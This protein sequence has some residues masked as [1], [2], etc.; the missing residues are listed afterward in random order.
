MSIPTPELY[1]RLGRFW[2]E[3]VRAEDLATVATEKALAAA[4][5]ATDPAAL[6]DLAVEYQHL[7]GFNLP[8]YESVFIDPSAML[9]APAT[10]QVQSLYDRAGWTPPAGLRIGASDHLGVELL[11]L[12][13]WLAA[14]QTEYARILLTRCL[15]WWAPVFVLALRRLDPHPF[16]AALG[17]LTLAHLLAD[18][19]ADPLPPGIDPLPDLPSPPAYQDRGIS[20]PPPEAAAEDISVGLS[21]ILD[22]LLT[23][24]R[25]GLF[26]TRADIG[27]ISRA[28]DLP[29][30]M[31]ER[32]RMLDTLFRQAGQYD[33]APDLLKRLT[34]V[35][36]AAGVT[37]RTWAGQYPAWGPYAGAWQQRVTASQALLKQLEAGLAG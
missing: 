11:A 10:A 14:G 17:E 20:V 35:F 1:R 30:V 3:E 9:M 28:L 18:L 15:A 12:A 26:L 8:P 24:R 6:T 25:A 32:R 34:E 23:P 29:P 21:D 37:Y 16:Y 19:P 2:L 22:H 33:L 7:F 4:L 31:S 27:R 13:A 36:T 5:P